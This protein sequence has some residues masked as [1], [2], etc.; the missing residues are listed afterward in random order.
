MNQA[1][2]AGLIDAMMKVAEFD[3]SGRPRLKPLKKKPS[4]DL[5]AKTVATGI[6]AVKPPTALATPASSSVSKSL[7]GKQK[8]GLAGAAA[9]GLAA[10]H[11]VNKRKQ[12]QQASA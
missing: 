2:L 8:A 6:P 9:I 12:K 11:V 10:R 3:I 5:G 4:V 7:T 1:H